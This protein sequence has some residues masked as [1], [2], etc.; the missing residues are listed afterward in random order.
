MEP[1]S[2]RRL[3]THA[4]NS[5]LPKPCVA[6]WSCA[7]AFRAVALAP[8]TPGSMGSIM[9]KKSQ[10]RGA[11][12]RRL[13][14]TKFSRFVQVVKPRGLQLR[15]IQGVTDMPAALGAGMARSRAC[16]KIHGQLGQ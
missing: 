14:A 10:E 12:P 6:A 15:S 8:F 11:R 5:P 1:A 4:E 13:K 3:F 16:E 2:A 7:T 9:A